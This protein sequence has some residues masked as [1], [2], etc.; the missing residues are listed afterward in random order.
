MA[1]TDEERRAARNAASRKW[2]EAHKAAKAAQ[3]KAGKAKPKAKKVECKPKA[4][5]A[6]PKAAAKAGCAKLEKQVDKFAEKAAKATEAYKAALKEAAAL[7]GEVCKSGDEKLVLKASKA[8]SKKL[9]LEI[10]L[11]PEDGKAELTPA[12]QPP[13][14]VRIP[15]SKPAV[16]DKSEEDKPKEKAETVDPTTLTGIDAG[17]PA[18]EQEDEDDDK[19]D[20]ERLAELREK[21]PDERTEK[22]QEELEELEELEQAERD[23]EG[24]ADTMRELEEQGAYDD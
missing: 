15:K 3:N 16:A 5:K 8:F 21:D 2:Y 19:T 14:A 10:A 20:A 22:E 4:G 6:K 1:M 7:F 12:I 23:A 17:E 18:E 9:S 11:S 24:Q 13:K